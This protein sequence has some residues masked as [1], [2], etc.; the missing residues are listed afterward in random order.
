MAPAILRACRLHH[1]TNMR[2][3]TTLVYGVRRRYFRPPYLFANPRL[4]KFEATSNI[5][6]G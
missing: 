4:V 2:D 1:E 6:S 5:S 3:M